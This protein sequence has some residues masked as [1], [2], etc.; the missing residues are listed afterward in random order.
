MVPYG[1]LWSGGV[2]DNLFPALS[3]KAGEGADRLLS[4]EG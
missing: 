2:V 3:P 4:V 1:P